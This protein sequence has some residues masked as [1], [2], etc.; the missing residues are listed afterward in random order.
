ML[1]G[2]KG[3]EVDYGLSKELL[4]S[5]YG[6]SA[7]SPVRD[8][9]IYDDEWCIEDAD[10]EHCIEKYNKSINRFLSYE[11][12]VWIT[13]YARSNLFT[14]IKEFGYDY[15]YS[16]TDSIKVFNVDS[17]MDYI[18]R[19]NANCKK[20]LQKA[21]DYHHLDISLT[22]PKSIDGVEHPIGVWSYE[23][24]YSRFKTLGAKR[25]VTE[26]DGK[27]TIT[28]AGLSKKKPVAYMIEHYGSVFDALKDGM[29]IPA[30]WTGKLTHK[31]YDEPF[32]ATVTDIQGHQTEVHEESYIHMSPCEFTLSLSS[33][34]W[35]LLQVLRVMEV[36]G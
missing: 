28:I 35:D 5:V 3:K 33:E 32:T 30:K 19:Y 17:H 7:T 10:I 6:M 8:E 25:Y 26:Q 15:V 21:F 14:G 9:I 12:S 20:M 22:H 27:Q 13:A 4:N 18:E 24:C 11:W 23:G 2:V 1:K 31:Y 29:Y 34:Y 16:D 36:K